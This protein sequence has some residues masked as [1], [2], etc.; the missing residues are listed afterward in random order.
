MSGA[1]IRHAGS[2]APDQSPG[3]FGNPQFGGLGHSK[4]CDECG[5]PHSIG[6]GWSKFGPGRVLWR[7]PR[8]T[9]AR[10]ARKSGVA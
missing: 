7:C 9:V 10:A 2:A 1:I 5:K 3:A 4:L 8:C 6:A